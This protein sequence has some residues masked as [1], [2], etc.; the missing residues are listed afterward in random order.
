MKIRGK[1]MG[2]T[3][4]DDYTVKLGT[5]DN[6]NPHCI[7]FEI[8]GWVTPTTKEELNYQKVVNR[9]TKRAKSKVYELINGSDFKS[10]V[11][12][13]DLDLRESGIQYGKR[14]YYNC[15]VT[16]YQ[17]DDVK[18]LTAI[19]PNIQTFSDTIIKEVFETFEHFTF[20]KKKK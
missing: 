14:S 13:L 2:L 19:T 11:F 9:L 15:E 6:K 3:S 7:Y 20:H 4:S 18:E 1:E 10:N 17:N 12:I 5:V 8:K 16:L